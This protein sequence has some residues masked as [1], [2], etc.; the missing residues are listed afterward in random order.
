[1]MKKSISL[2]QSL[3]LFTMLTPVMGLLP[4]TANAVCSSTTPSNGDTVTCSGT[5]NLAATIGDLSTTYDIVIDDNAVVDST[6]GSGDTAFELQGGTLAMGEDSLIHT[7]RDSIF[8]DFGDFEAVLEAGAEIISDMGYGLFLTQGGDITIEQGA[9]I[10]TNRGAINDDG[11]GT[12][13]VID[14]A[15]YLSGTYSVNLSSTDDK[16]ILRTGSELDGAVNLGGGDDIVELRGNGS[17]DDRFFDVETLDVFADSTG[18]TLSGASSQFESVDVQSG[19]LYNDGSFTMSGGTVNVRSGAT[20][21]GVGTTEGDVTNFGFVAPGNTFGTMTV[22]GDYTQDATGQLNVD[23]D[24][25]GTA[26]KLNVTDTANLAGTVNFT[27]LGGTAFDLTDGTSFTFLEAGTITGAF[28]TIADLFPAFDFDVTQVGQELI[29][30]V[31]GNTLSYEGN[32]RSDSENKSAKAFENFLPDTSGFESV[33]IDNALNNPQQAP[34]VL[35]SQSNILT[36]A[37]VGAARGAVG[38][39][40]QVVKSRMNAV[41][42]QA[43]GSQPGPSLTGA[44]LAQ[45]SFNGS[46][47]TF[48]TDAGRDALSVLKA[49]DGGRGVLGD[50]TGLWAQVVGGMGS[51]DSDSYGLGSEYATYGFAVGGEKVS[52]KNADVKLGSFFGFTESKTKVKTIGDESDIANY[53]LGVYSSYTPNNRWQFSGALS[54]SYLDF[55]TERPTVTGVA[56]AS[57]GGVATFGSAEVSYQLP[58]VE[59]ISLTPFAQIEGSLVRRNAYQ[60][61]GAGLLNNDVEAQTSRFLTSVVGLRAADR[62]VFGNERTGKD[63]EKLGWALGSDVSLGWAHQ[64]ADTNVATSASFQGTNIN[65]SSEGPRRNRDSMRIGFNTSIENTAHENILGFVRYEGD[66][67]SDAQEHIIR[68]GL[69]WLF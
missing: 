29:A 64:Y 32:A 47:Q 57:F 36:N 43:L 40:V 22:D 48:T 12:G 8:T 58:T 13:T 1:M 15:G 24:T 38:Q 49:R 52:K 19:A 42:G 30:T 41:A 31:S 62:W 35:A 54:A 14:N 45:T 37:S 6:S 7:D 16:L 46:E 18:W 20:Y 27:P 39:V 2:R 53:Q 33:T 66:I 5:T 50:N 55:D 21:G 28:D 26:D 34:K 25:D 56:G 44:Q 23:V 68:V 59:T 11:W 65:F 4:T 9:R 67:A 63:G 10:D 69:A 17:E 60:E 3:L 51:H 61:E